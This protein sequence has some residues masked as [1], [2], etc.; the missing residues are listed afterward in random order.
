VT[1]AGTRDPATLTQPCSSR[2]GPGAGHSA[3]TKSLSRCLIQINVHLAKEG[4]LPTRGATFD[5]RTMSG[6]LYCRLDAD[7]PPCPALPWAFGAGLRKA[8][9][10][11]RP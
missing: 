11:L 10:Y 3:A 5:P 7:P 6:R 8:G 2:G 4:A 1:A 9:G